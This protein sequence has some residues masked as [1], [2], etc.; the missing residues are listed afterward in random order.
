MGF[1]AIEVPTALGLSPRPD[2]SELPGGTW[3]A[4]GAL[5]AA[6]LMRVLGARDGPVIEVGGYDGTRESPSGARNSAAV[7][8]QTAAIAAAVGQTLDA[9]DVPLVV[10]GDCSVLLGSSLALRRRGRFGLAFVDGHLDFRHLGNTVQLSAVAG[11]DLAVVTGRGPE[12]LAGVDGLGP[13][14]ADVDVVALGEREH[15]PVTSDI[16]ATAIDVVDLAELRRRNPQRAGLAA[17]ARLRDAGCEAAWLHLDVDVLDSELMPAVD[18]PQADG[19]AAPELVALLDAL[20]RD[21]FVAGAEI[22]IYDPDLDPDGCCAATL[23][24]IVG[25]GLRGRR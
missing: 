24:E 6:G 15:N 3:R 19:L 22:T 7:A 4:P 10:G 14:V 25:T 17:I 9:G 13:Y 11:E 1:I 12:L 8:D 21:G 20:T 23:V 18:S 5:R 2:N 16:H